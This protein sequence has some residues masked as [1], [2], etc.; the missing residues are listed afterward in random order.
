MMDR[1][2][3]ENIRDGVAAW[4][5]GDADM[6]TVTMMDTENLATDWLSMQEIVAALA[7]AG[8]RVTE[9]DADN[10]CWYCPLCDAAA[11]YLRRLEH[12]ESCAY[13]RAV[14][15]MGAQV[16]DGR[17]RGSMI[18]ELFD[19]LSRGCPDGVS[20]RWLQDAQQR[21]IRPLSRT[22]STDAFDI[23]FPWD[24]LNSAYPD[25]LVRRRVEA[26]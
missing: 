12:A 16:A 20:L 26:V 18:L 3:V 10:H 22:G 11:P 13:R 7:G 24:E 6:A 1:E 23:L 5:D 4:I 15:L 21:T 9:Y 17:R 25:F 19:W 14:E 2:R 8:G